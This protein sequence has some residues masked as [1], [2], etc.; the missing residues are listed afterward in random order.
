MRGIAVPSP[1][2]TSF[3]PP[4]DG[5]ERSR[6]ARDI[7][8]PAILDPHAFSPQPTR[9]LSGVCRPRRKRDPPIAAQHPVPRQVGIGVA[10]QHA[11]HQACAPRQAGASGDD[12]VTGHGAHGNGADGSEDARARGL[13]VAG[14]LA[15]R[16]DPARCR[17]AIDR[18]CVGR[19]RFAH[20]R[21]HRRDQAESVS[22]RRRGLPMCFATP[23]RSVV[24]RN[25][26]R[27]VGWA[28]AVRLRTDH[29]GHA[30]YRLPCPP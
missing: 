1:G 19:L 25:A 13:R 14:G 21:S 29:D 23:P 12:A 9:L 27:C 20:P 17:S 5:I 6:S 2:S 28:L 30:I 4:H 22:I 18:G 7:A 10:C 16:G 15:S 24:W 3:R 8:Y 11:R 26:W